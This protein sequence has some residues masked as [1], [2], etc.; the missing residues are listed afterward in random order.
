MVGFKP[1][2]INLVHFLLRGV[3]WAQD[4][5]QGIIL[6]CAQSIRLQN[7]T[8]NTILATLEQYSLGPLA[9]SHLYLLTQCVTAM[10]TWW[11]DLV[12]S[13][14]LVPEMFTGTLQ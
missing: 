11:C 14:C 2:K 12:T 4:Y 3:V 6:Q 7:Y 9:L 5:K 1:K 13:V 8:L 10:E